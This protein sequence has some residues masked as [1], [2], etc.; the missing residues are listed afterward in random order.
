[1]R[2]AIYARVSTDKQDADNQ[3]LALEKWIAS[4]EW[5]ISAR[6][7]EAETAWKAGH[8]PELA[9]LRQDA[10]QRRFDAVVVWALDRLTRQG[11]AAILQ[12]VD[13]FRAYNVRIISYQE[14]WTEAPGQLGDLL[15]AIT[16]WVAN[17]ESQR[18]S[19]R[20]KAG[21]E[22]ARAHGKQIGRAKGRKDSPEVRRKRSGYF[23]R[24]E[25]EREQR[26]A[27]PKQA[28]P[29]LDDRVPVASR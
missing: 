16:G 13:G 29:C 15:Y 27:R 8:Q 24:Q 10:R 18:R 5:Q 28:D 23:A 25:R 7:I 19:E 21:M 26:N 3:V 4:R 22:R 17:M 6:Y 14:S 2:V 20:T 11:V 9:R 12:V 1:M